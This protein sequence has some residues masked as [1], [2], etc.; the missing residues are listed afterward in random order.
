MPISGMKCSMMVRM[1]STTQTAN[2]TMP[3]PMDC[4][5]WKRTNGIFVVGLEDEEDDSRDDGD[6]CDGRGGVV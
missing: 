3:S 1:A 6:V 4:Q 5:A 2:H